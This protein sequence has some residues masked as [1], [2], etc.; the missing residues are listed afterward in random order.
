MKHEY[1]G[2]FFEMDY[3]KNI[4][5]DLKDKKILA[6]LG[7]NCRILL[8]HIGKIANLGKDSV[9]YRMNQ[10]IKKDLYRGNLVIF[11][12]YSVGISLYSILLKL[13]EMDS[14][15]ENET[16]TF[17]ENHPFISWAGQTQGTYDYVINIASADIKHFDQLLRNLKSTIKSKIKDY[18]ILNI[19]KFYCCNTIPNVFKKESKVDIHFDK[20]DTSFGSLLKQPYCS[21]EDKK[22]EL[23]KIDL[24][25]IANI[26]N[27]ARLSLQEIS[28]KTGIKPD[29][30]KNRI[31]NLIK[32]NVILAFR[33]SINLSFLRFHGHIMF[34]RLYSHIGDEQKKEFE[35]YFKVND[36][37]FVFE[38]LSSYYDFQVYTVAKDPY[39]F[40]R[41][42]NDVRNK[43]S[44]IIEEYDS[45]LILNDF[46]FTSLPE[47][48]INILTSSDH[49]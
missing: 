37:I 23:D 3:G 35:N 17:F 19:A 12:P 20:L 15:R 21:I 49:S 11:N 48:I 32:K 29:T 36:F 8:G 4:K 34:F 27:N 7:E 40:S 44:S 26:G 9:R 22:I 41:I 38:A 10:L 16:K 18:K 46:K 47:G 43:F 31:I 13:E 1:R 33:A 45:V 42:L 28:K 39:D 14:K 6:A 25:I 30:I 5:L 24:L 2:M